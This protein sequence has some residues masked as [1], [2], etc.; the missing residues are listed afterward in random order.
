MTREEV[1]EIRIQKERENKLDELLNSKEE[2]S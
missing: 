1:E 2:I